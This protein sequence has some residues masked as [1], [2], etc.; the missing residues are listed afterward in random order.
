[1]CGSLRAHWGGPVLDKRAVSKS[2]ADKIIAI[3]EDHW[4]D[5]KSL[6]IAPAK[7]SKSVSAFA[8]TA[9]GEM[10]I[11]IDEVKAGPVKTRRWRGFAD[12]EAANAHV[13]VFEGLM[14]LG[15]H[16]EATFLASEHHP[17]LVLHITV[18]KAKGIINATDGT[19]YI[20]RNAQNLPVVGEEALHRLR[21]DK[22]VVSF[23]DT[24]VAIPPEEITNSA[25][26]LKFILSV[27]P[28]AEP[29]EWLKKQNVLMDGKPT[30]AGILLFSD[31]PQASLP[32]RSAIKLY[33]YKTRGDEASRDTLAFDPLTIEGCLYDQITEAVKRTKEVIEGMKRL[34]DTSLVDVT[35]PDE[36]LHE[37]ITNAVLHRD[38]S[39]P[40]DV[41]VRVYESDSKC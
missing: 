33:Q 4:S 25:T 14:P 7:L 13:Q 38:Y 40:A 41:H 35:Y 29:E 32:K 12:A 15:G 16:Y 22:G 18:F 30:A 9:G 37:I 36:T 6:D 27:V 5:V 11:G 20:R 19:P 17:G 39:I 10:F 23:E 26:A 24:P 21:L 2:E 34:G 28:S 3:E 31:E 1:V 8:N